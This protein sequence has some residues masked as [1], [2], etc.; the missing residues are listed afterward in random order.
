MAEEVIVIGGGGHARVLLDILRVD[1]VKLLGYTDLQPVSRSKSMAALK[2]LGPDDVILGYSSQ[3]VGLVNGIGSLPG[4]LLRNRIFVQFREEGYRFRSVVHS[5]AVIAK[6]VV[7]GDGV[8]VMAG[9]VIQPGTVIG[10]GVIV[11]TRASIDHDC[12]IEAH[13]H[14]AP[15]AVLCGGVHLSAGV[16]IGSGATLI[17]GMTIGQQVVVG[18][19]A[20][21][22]RP[23]SDYCTVFPARSIVKRLDGDNK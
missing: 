2:W 1:D 19:G 9:A 12:R 14:I 20:V 10:D 16:H 17:Q 21:V 11:N 6:D 4:N 15:G 7:L 22:T 18:A 13:C 23:V 5:S 3:Q 8:Q